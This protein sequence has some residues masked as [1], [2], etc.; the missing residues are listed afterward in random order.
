MLWEVEK[1]SGV[2]PFDSSS[3]YPVT[4]TLVC[5]GV[6]LERPRGLARH[7]ALAVVSGLREP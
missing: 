1:G 4:V 2:T 5:T 7:L 3:S 6:P